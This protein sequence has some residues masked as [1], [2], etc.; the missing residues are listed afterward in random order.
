[1]KECLIKSRVDLGKGE[2]SIAA[3]NC[4]DV[5]ALLFQKLKK[6]HEVGTAISDKDVLDDRNVVIRFHNE[7]GIHQIQ[8]F[9]NY[10]IETLNNG[11]EADDD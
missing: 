1:M 8:K 3:V 4:D 5:P 9:L 11:E 7:D 6:P 2:W 10:I